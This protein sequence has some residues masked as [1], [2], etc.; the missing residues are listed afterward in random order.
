MMEVVSGNSDQSKT[1]LS[2]VVVS[3]YSSSK[4]SLSIVVESF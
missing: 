3:G 4:G 2:E 1:Y